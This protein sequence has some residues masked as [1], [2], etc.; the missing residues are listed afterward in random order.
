MTTAE[1]FEASR[2]R[3]L[4]KV[5]QQLDVLHSELASLYRSGSTDHK[6]IAVIWK[7]IDDLEMSLLMEGVNYGDYATENH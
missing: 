4:W 6:R 5:V 2:K 1:E 3:Y 7:T